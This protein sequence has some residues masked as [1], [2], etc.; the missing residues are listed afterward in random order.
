MT[1]TGVARFER[2]VDKAMVEKALIVVEP[3]DPFLAVSHSLLDLGVGFGSTLAQALLKDVKVWGKHED[4]EAT[5][6]WVLAEALSTGNVEVHEAYTIL[7]QDLLNRRLARAVV[8][9]MYDSVLKKLPIRNQIP[10]DL[11]GDKVVALSVYLSRPHAARGVAHT[12]AKVI[13][14]LF[15]ELPD[16][17]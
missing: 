3:L 6:R 8:G 13:G 15:D 11:G 4:D 9:V 16:E 7:A 14:E 10:K 1:E 5:E 2:V 17:C 12:V